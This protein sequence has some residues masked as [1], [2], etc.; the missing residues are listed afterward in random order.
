[1]SGLYSYARVDEHGNVSQGSQGS[2]YASA[3]TITVCGEPVYSTDDK[4]DWAVM[5]A[6]I[7]AE[8]KRDG[9]K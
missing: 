2:F 9:S 3:H 6:R 5:L 1:M 4:R 8:V 7:I